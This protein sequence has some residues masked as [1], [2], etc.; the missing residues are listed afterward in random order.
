MTKPWKF[1]PWLAVA[2]L[3]ASAWWWQTEKDAWRAP[4]ARNPEL[5]AVAEIPAP[6]VFHAKN[7]LERPLLWASRRPTG[8]DEPQGGMAQ[9]LMQS[10]LTAVIAS[11]KDQI[12][13]LQRKDGSPLR[14]SGESKPWRIES[15]DGRKA[16]FLSVDQ[17]RVERP[18]EH[19]ATAEPR[20]AVPQGRPPKPPAAQ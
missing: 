14:L 13:V 10:R 4:V 19:A 1:A 5:P 12:A 7:A 17:Q 15:F 11:G 8:S 16:V 2:A 20:P 3:A 18:L 6:P 9:E